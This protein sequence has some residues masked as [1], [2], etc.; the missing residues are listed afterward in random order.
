M[1]AS[2]SGQWGPSR[3][4]T[5]SGQEHHA[6]ASRTRRAAGA[7]ERRLPPVAGTSPTTR[8]RPPSTAPSHAG[9]ESEEKAIQLGLAEAEGRHEAHWTALL[10]EQAGRPRRPS[11]RS[12]MLGFLARHF[13]SVFILALAQ[14]AESRSPYADDPH[15]SPAMAADERIHEEVVR[16][17]AV[18][19]R[20]P[21]SGSFRAAVFGGSPGLVS[22]LSLVA[23]MAATG[24][25][26][27]HVVLLSG[28][29]GLLAGTLSMGMGGSSPS[30]PSARCS[31]H[32]DR[33][34][35]RSP[36]PRRST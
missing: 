33:P 34:R 18:R 4:E 19:G 11:A 36:P 6:I 30:G 1:R 9:R 5:T 28:G 25:V 13:G 14:R 7:H 12:R 21:L 20:T 16:A 2:D 26:A 32:P 3:Q 17:L 31:P 29:V 10:G 27:S 15:A 24:V 8:P 22:N 35:S 23:G